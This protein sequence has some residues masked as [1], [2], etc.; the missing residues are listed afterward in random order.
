MYVAPVPYHSFNRGDAEPLVPGEMATLTF[1]LLPVSYRIP[2]GHR[3]RLA[4]AGAD[5]DHFAQLPADP[6]TLRFHR[7]THIDLSTFQ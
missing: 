5:R 7:V 3:L 6:P 2:A 1:D 4:L